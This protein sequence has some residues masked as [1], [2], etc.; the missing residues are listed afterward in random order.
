MS[1]KGFYFD[2][3]YEADADPWQ[4]RTR[5]YEERKR[6]LTL[7]CLP[8]R[9]YE[10]CFEPGAAIGVLSA[11][12]A[13]RC[14]QVLAM[15]IS[16]VALRLA[17]ADLPENVLL[18]QGAVP[19]DWPHEPFDLVVLSEV[20]YYLDKTDCA[21]LAGL[22][23]H[24]AQD[25]VAVHWRHPVDEYPLSGDEVHE[26]LTEAALG[27]GMHQLVDHREDDLKLDVWSHDAR[28]V[29]VRTGVPHQ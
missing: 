22:A 15:D 10:S 14:D 29:A 26:L 21:E 7:A 16:P 24:N 8:E 4:F 23:V 27:A 1:L 20:G 5:D 2:R 25:L 28:S 11:Q 19:R 18:R 12:L 9:H 6:Q 17:A 13:R 3:L